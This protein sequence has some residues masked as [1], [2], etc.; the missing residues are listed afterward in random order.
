MVEF[1]GGILK[2]ALP[3]R[4][5]KRILLTMMFFAFFLILM[6]VG[7]I[8]FG[9]YFQLDEKEKGKKGN[10]PR[11][12]VKKLFNRAARK[13]E[14][15]SGEIKKRIFNKKYP[16][17]ELGAELESI[18]LQE[19]GVDSKPI[20]DLTIPKPNL[21]SEPNLKELEIPLHNPIPQIKIE[22]IPGRAK[23]KE[24]TNLVLSG[25]LYLD[26]GKEI[27]MDSK[28]I[29]DMDWEESLFQHFRRVGNAELLE[30]DGSIEYKNNESLFHFP[31]QEIDKIVFYDT[32]ITIFPNSKD[33][34]NFLFFTKDTFLFKQKITEELRQF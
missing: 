23:T 10:I 18:L 13:K 22:E 33:L 16:E 25:I 2:S 1:L 27:P 7:F 21:E 5:L 29:N 32:A 11:F 9:N 14:E 15:Y 8:L 26:Y 12:L 17:K 6:G 30:K 28:V 4:T 24:K 34:P 19:R 31:I 20:Q 3:L